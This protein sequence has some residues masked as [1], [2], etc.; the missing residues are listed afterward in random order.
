M[1]IPTG[2]YIYC[3]YRYK[4]VQDSIFKNTKT[5]QKPE[6]PKMEK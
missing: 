4:G 3:E 1:V 5:W 6:C 2:N